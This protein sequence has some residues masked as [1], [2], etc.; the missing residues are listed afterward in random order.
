MILHGCACS[1]E[2]LLFA[3]TFKAFFHD[4]DHLVQEF[5]GVVHILEA[6]S[7]TPCPA[8]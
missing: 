1:P 6:C 5:F 8:E 7:L 2:P 4:K 3:Y